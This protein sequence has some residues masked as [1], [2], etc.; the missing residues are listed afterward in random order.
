MADYSLPGLLG[1]GF[2]SNYKP[3]SYIDPTS[4]VVS[5]AGD[6][7]N[8]QPTLATD[9]AGRAAA[10]PAN[11]TRIDPTIDPGS[12]MVADAPTASPFARS[13]ARYRQQGNVDQVYNRLAQGPTPIDRVVNFFSSQDPTKPGMD[14][15][16]Q[17]ADFY[18]RP[19]VKSRVL[20]DKQ[21][22]DAA[23]NDPRGTMTALQPL[24]DK[25]A[26]APPMTA[27]GRVVGDQAG[28][29]ARAVAAGVPYDTAH[30]F[31]EPHQYSEEEFVNGT[32][33]LSWNQAS[34]LWGFQH[35]VLPQQQMM[36]DAVAGANQD[37]NAASKMLQE[38]QGRNAPQ[39]RIDAATKEVEARR[40][41]VQNL[42]MR[43][44]TPQT[45]AYPNMQNVQ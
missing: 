19:E 9:L 40:N 30:Y 29:Q 41:A 24:V 12:S 11:N 14:Q 36:V 10:I 20:G 22:L 31:H 34:R 42:V 21:I 13:L 37:F 18:A 45:Y 3:N 27:N 23:L 2:G 5:S 1:F 4:K 8:A 33:G 38:L 16:Q 6:V 44:T 26:Q 17:M 7:T 32:R 43:F 28:T 25:A 15:Q 35:Y 39:A